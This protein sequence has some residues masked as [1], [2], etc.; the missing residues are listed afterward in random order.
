MIEE[1]VLT[2]VIAFIAFWIFSSLWE[3][4]EERELEENKEQHGRNWT[5]SYNK[6][7]YN[8]KQ[9]EEKVFGDD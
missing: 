9:W 7:S 3:R 6:E 8:M 5:N 4:K 2:T 1:F